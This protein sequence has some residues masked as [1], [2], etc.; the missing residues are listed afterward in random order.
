MQHLNALER[1]VIFLSTLGGALELYDFII[2]VFLAGTL[3]ELFFPHQ[4]SLASLMEVFGVFAIGYF[5]R[6]LGGIIFSHFGDKYGRKKSFML[7]LMLMA[8]PTFLMGLLPTSQS[9]GVWAAVLLVSLRLLQGLAIGGEIPGAITFAGEHVNPLYRGLTCGIIFFGINLG[10]M[11]G[12]GMNVLLGTTLNHQQ[13]I[14]WGWRIPFLL[15]GLLGVLSFY[16]R[17]QLT[18]TPIFLNYSKKLQDESI[19]LIVALKSHPKALLRGVALTAL[20]ATNI[21]LLF[22][23]VPTYF[24][25][26]LH[27]PKDLVNQLNTLNIF[28]FSGLL[29]LTAWLSDRLGRRLL[30]RIGSLGFVLLAYLLFFWLTEEKISHLI[31]VMII[32][33]VLGACVQGV[34]AC[35]LIELFP[36]QIRY[37]GTA[38]T[39]NL[40]FAIFG[41]LAP[42][43]ATYLISKTGDLAAPAYYLMAAAFLCF[44]A[45]LGLK[46]KQ[47]CELG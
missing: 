38:L 3:S 36:T 32:F 35:T 12:S 13:F 9:I 14:S 39:Y 19:P 7:T 23:Y 45:T 27:Y 37:T 4:N 33:S 5:V 2:Y 28:L 34:F 47:S 46:N 29:I 31:I 42:L 17:R 25:S 21:S 40:G 22:L 20:G 6:P 15:G 24:S 1:K 41:G 43:T 8:L 16:L 10:L 30:L 44:I 11:L 18:E 26:V